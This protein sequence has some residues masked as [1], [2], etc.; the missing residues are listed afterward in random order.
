MK[1]IYETDSKLCSL[2]SLREHSCSPFVR[3]RRVGRMS[4]FYARSPERLSE[5]G[6]Q[7]YRS[8]LG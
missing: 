4:F 6:E 3:C 7:V 2:T 1:M 5:A 8:D